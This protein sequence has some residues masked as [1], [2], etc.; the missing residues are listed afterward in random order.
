MVSTWN[1][2]LWDG[3]ARNRLLKDIQNFVNNMKDTD[4]ASYEALRVDLDKIPE[5]M[6]KWTGKLNTVKVENPA[7]KV[8]GQDTTK[9]IDI[10]PPSNNN[11]PTPTKPTG[12]TNN[13]TPSQPTQDTWWKPLEVAKDPVQQTNKWTGGY[14]SNSGEGRQ[15]QYGY[16]SNNISKW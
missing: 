6:N 13:P 11:I 10:A 14:Y 7:D 9:N 1:N 2:T 8:G 4:P 16:S 5:F 3:I 15:F 12:N